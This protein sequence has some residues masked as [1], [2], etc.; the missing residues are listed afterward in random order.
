MD[1]HRVG[2]VCMLCTRR[3]VLFLF[4]RGKN[5]EPA[6]FSIRAGCRFYD[7]NSW[8]LLLRPGKRVPCDVPPLQFDIPSPKG[9]LQRKQKRRRKVHRRFF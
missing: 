6:D 3:D 8:K 5:R 7:F 4:V 9:T 1:L 2:R